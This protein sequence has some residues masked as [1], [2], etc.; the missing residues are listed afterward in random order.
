VTSSRPWKRQPCLKTID[1]TLSRQTILEPLGIG[2]KEGS[3]GLKVETVDGHPVTAA[4][5]GPLVLR[6]PF[7]VSSLQSCSYAGLLGE[8]GPSQD[9]CSPAKIGG[10]TNSMI[11]DQV[12]WVRIGA[13][14]PPPARR[15]SPTT[16]PRMAAAKTSTGLPP[17]T[18]ANV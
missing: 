3:R 18:V 7:D 17:G 13:S 12:M 4:E 5:T 16:V 14:T 11:S 1:L 6:A 10:R 9:H 15:C 2:L 8:V